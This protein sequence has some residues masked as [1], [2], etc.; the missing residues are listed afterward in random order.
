MKPLFQIG[1]F[2]LANA[3]HSSFKINADVLTTDDWNALAHLALQ[4]VPSFGSVVPVP[5][6]GIPFADALRPFATEGPVLVVDDVLTTGIS[7]LRAAA[8]YRLEGK[9]VTES[10]ILLVA[11]SR[12]PQLSWVH[13]IFTLADLRHP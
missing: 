6:G 9:I 1:S 10:C 13:S 4:I 11:F 7:I 2:E 12:V 3:G 5:T 8:P